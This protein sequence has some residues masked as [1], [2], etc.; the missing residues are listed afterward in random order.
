MR[1]ARKLQG[2]AV[3]GS[4]LAILAGTAA[5]TPGASVAA[6]THNCGS[7]TITIEHPA[8]NGAPASKFKLTVSQ[9]MTQGVSCQAAASFFNKL[10]TSTTG[11]PEKY[12]C[13]IGHFKVPRGK[14]PEICSRPGRR[15]QF[16]GQGG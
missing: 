13:T 4:A 2:P 15:I 10:Y 7:K 1:A 16:A 9:I 5:L 14:V 11:V 8:E 12:K 6:A 3:L